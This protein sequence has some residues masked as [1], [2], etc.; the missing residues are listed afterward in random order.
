MKIGT[1]NALSK[2]GFDQV[3]CNTVIHLHKTLV[4]GSGGSIKFVLETLFADQSVGIP[5][6]ESEE[7]F[8][9]NFCYVGFTLVM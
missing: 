2:A 9:A 1:S 8:F 5:L 6:H 3:L 7:L 4:F